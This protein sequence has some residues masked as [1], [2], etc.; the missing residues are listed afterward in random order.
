MTSDTVFKE[1]E[2]K[3]V[4]V[5]DIMLKDDLTDFKFCLFAKSRE[6]LDKVLGTKNS[7]LFF[8]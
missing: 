5:P 3:I 1:Y 2:G 7:Y 4:Q 6:D 8:L